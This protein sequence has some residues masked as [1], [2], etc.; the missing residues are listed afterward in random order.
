MFLIRK[1]ELCCDDWF[2]KAIIGAS[3]TFDGAEFSSQGAS[4]NKWYVD[5]LG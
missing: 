2:V 3:V 4:S 5:C 1:G